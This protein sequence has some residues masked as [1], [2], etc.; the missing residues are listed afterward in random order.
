MIFLKLFIFYLLFN[1]LHQACLLT[2][3][4]QSPQG[5]DDGVLSSAHSFFSTARDTHWNETWSC[6]QSVLKG[7]ENVFC[8]GLGNVSFQREVNP[9]HALIVELG[10]LGLPTHVELAHSGQDHFFEYQ[11][12]LSCAFDSCYDSQPPICNVDSQMK[13][14]HLFSSIPIT[15]FFL[16]D[17][18]GDPDCVHGFL[19]CKSATCLI[20][21][22]VVPNCVNCPVF[23][24]YRFY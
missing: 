11:F 19:S 8:S 20:S 9:V 3:A 18:V 24:D 10:F 15:L 4:K 23:L 6:Q 16:Q 12:S 2:D 22:D 5:E 13:P 7:R 17:Q 14:V 21:L 1:T